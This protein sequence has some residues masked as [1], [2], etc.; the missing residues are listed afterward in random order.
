M[1]RLD[2]GD[3]CDGS[4]CSFFVGGLLLESVVFFNND[5]FLYE[6]YDLSV[7]MFPMPPH[8]YVVL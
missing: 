5:D 6:F 7:G 4:F 3:G 1:R 2:D 8:A